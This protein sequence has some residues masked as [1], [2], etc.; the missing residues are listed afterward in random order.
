MALVISI[1]LNCTALAESV[2]ER[3]AHAEANFVASMAAVKE[4]AI[5]NPAGAIGM[6]GTAVCLVAEPCGLVGSFTAAMLQ[7]AGLP[8]ALPGGISA[9]IEYNKVYQPL[10]KEK[11]RANEERKS[12]DLRNRR[13]N[14]ICGGSVPIRLVTTWGTWTADNEGKIISGNYDND[15]QAVIN[16]TSSSCNREGKV[17][18]W[19]CN[20]LLGWADKTFDALKN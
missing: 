1:A 4:F 18:R 7:L 6:V 11:L 2:V 15:A 10:Y 12:S 8:L 20:N 14:L 5:T 19:C 3:R 16:I 17:S 13:Y 9:G